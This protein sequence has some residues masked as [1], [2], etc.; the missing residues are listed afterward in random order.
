M[1]AGRIVY[2]L[3][4]RPLSL[5]KTCIRE[6]GPIE[7]WITERG[8]KEMEK[9]AVSLSLSGIESQKS[10]LK[11]LELHMVVGKRFWYMAAF[12][13]VT[14]RRHLDREVVVHFYSD[15]T[16]TREQAKAL[17]RLPITA[18]FVKDQ[19]I[20]DR[21]ETGLPQKKFPHLR[22]RLENYPNIRKLISPHIGCCGPKI[23]LD[24][25]VLFYRK[26]EELGE[27]QERPEE[28]LCATDVEESY[29]Y[30]RADLDRLAGGRL[31]DRVNVGITGLVSENIKWDQLEQ[32]CA[33]L[34]QKY[35]THY[36]LEQALIAMMCVKAGY[37]QLDAGRYITGPS[38]A[39]AL[40]DAGVMQ[41]YV[42]LSKKWYF[43]S[44]WRTALNGMG[45]GGAGRVQKRQSTDWF[46]NLLPQRRK[47]PNF[48]GA[49][50][51]QLYRKPRDEIRRMSRWG[52][53]GYFKTPGWAKEM[54]RAAERLPPLP[55]VQNKPARQVWF[56]SGRKHWFQTAF[57][58]W[59]FQRW[60]RLRVVPVIVDDGTFD[61]E[62]QEKFSKIFPEHI[63]WKRE[64]CNRRFAEEFPQ[65]KYPMIHA[66]RERQ[67]LFRKLT[68]AF[69]RADEWR[70]LMDSDMLFFSEP[71]EMDQLLEQREVIFTQKDCKESY[72]YSQPLL[73]R[74]AGG[75][76][77]K[78]IN[79][80]IVQYNGARTD[81]DR[82][83]TWLT[84]MISKEGIAY[85][86]T[87]GTF[88]MVLARQKMQTL[89]AEAY[90][91][92]PNNPRTEDPLPVCGHYVA[93]S[94]P[95][96][97]AKGWRKALELAE[98]GNS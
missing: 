49:T 54:E 42:D 57:C 52:L 84:E 13:L 14:L 66:V 39:Q 20:R 15:G 98:A 76:L 56:L 78:A 2:R 16:L 44:N 46:E 72:G 81:W 28:I 29:G 91:V 94:K 50:K 87:Q 34:H 79:I 51:T 53:E 40:S 75:K 83:E 12:A 48:L 95:W 45:L 17:G 92:Y 9:A 74:L 21:V 47:F 27:W 43:R 22:E 36:Y 3:W 70:F 67:V 59:T 60:S 86:V 89:D 93:D 11:P 25:D 18:F 24:A 32:W 58:A 8:R 41:H 90:K 71:R 96:Y 4:F 55:Q 38:R 65:E 23:V 80:G 7:Q 88:A 10:Q 35:G 37:R 30:P 97:F 82:V 85:N 69:G 62:V 77:P 6:G 73:E 5:V 33:E 64:D 61:T 1:R 68:K 63:L 19:E 31:P 26:P